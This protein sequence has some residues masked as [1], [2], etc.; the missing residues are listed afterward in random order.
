MSRQSIIQEM[1]VLPDIDPE[2]EIQRRIDFIK[3]QLQQ[4]GARHLILGISGGVDSSTCGRLGQLATEQLNASL[5]DKN[6]RSYQFI[7]LRLPYGVQ[8]DEHDAQ[9]ALA[10]IQ[11]SQSLT[12]QC[13]TRRRRHSSANNGSGARRR[14]I[15]S[16]C[17]SCRFCQRQRQGT[18]SHGGPVRSS[19]LV[20][21][22]GG[23]VPTTRQKTLPVSTPSL[24]TVPVIWHLCLA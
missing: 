17:R 16:L 15:K 4:S 11:P 9:T 21:R 1:R 6:D 5:T 18:C 12:H 13:Q 20:G 2:Y 23:W 19:R 8:A 24:A 14:F 3:R 22:T 7:A 10:F